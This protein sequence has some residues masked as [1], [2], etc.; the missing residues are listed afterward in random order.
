MAAAEEDDK[1]P[2]ILK[3]ADARLPKTYSAE[4]IRAV[5][6]EEQTGFPLDGVQVVAR[7]EV[8]H[9]VGGTLP[10]FVVQEATTGP[11]GQFV[12]PGFPPRARPSHA[13][14]RGNAPELLLFKSGFEALRLRS[15]PKE[16]F[17][18]R[19]PNYKSMS[20][21][22]I[23]R[24]MASSDDAGARAVQRCF[25]DNMTIGLATFNGSEREWLRELR[26]IE[27]AIRDDEAPF[28]RGMLTAL[29]A[30]RSR[31]SVRKRPQAD[32]WDIEELFFRLD[33]L[34]EQSSPR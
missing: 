21:K 30:E 17:A 27:G 8:R 29:K 7:W 6:V 23:S 13:F 12:I 2:L 1:L 18:K 31:F 28:A 33:R 4:P 3:L 20:S 9:I 15:E 16:T 32:A 5:V 24:M 14:L 19:Y 11:Q 26:S 34:L 10:A 25:W 22:V